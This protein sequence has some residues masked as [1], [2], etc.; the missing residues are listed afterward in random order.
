[1]YLGLMNRNAIKKEESVGGKKEGKENMNNR[2]KNVGMEGQNEEGWTE[3]WIGIDAWDGGK[4][5]KR[6]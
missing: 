5:D 6:I 3:E 2:N 1:M 4:R